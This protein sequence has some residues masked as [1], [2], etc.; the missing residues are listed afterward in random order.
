MLTDRVRAIGAAWLGLTTGC[1]QCHDHKFDPITQKDFYA[2]GAFFADLQEPII[3]RREDGMVVASAED[4]KTLARL[5]AAVAEAKTRLEAVAPQLDGA[6]AQW[7]ADLSRYAV[8][9]PELAPDSKATPAEKTAARAVQAALKKDAKARNPKEHE[10][11]QTYFRTNAPPLFPAERDAVARAERQRQAFADGLPK[12]LVSVHSATP[13]T[14]RILPR[15]NWM[16][17]TGE[18]VKPALPHYL[19]R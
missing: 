6:Q 12:C 8:T 1:A 13:R 2:L 3:G 9:L 14:V 17:E 19:P 7:E 10:A 5:D 15:G 18:V 11:V 4:Q 16:D